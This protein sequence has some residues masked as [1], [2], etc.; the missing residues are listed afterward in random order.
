MEQE[1]GQLFKDIAIAV[2]CAISLSLF[3]SVLV[4]PMLAKQLYGV[5]EKRMEATAPLDGPRPPAML[6]VA[7][8]LLVPLTKLG[9]RM[10]D[11]IM[12]LLDRAISNP[13]SRIVT[14]ASLTLASILLVVA[15]FP[16]ME[17]LPQGNRNLVISILIPP[18]G[19]SYEERLEIGKY[20]YEAADPHFNTEKDGLPGIKD[21]FFV[22]APTINLFGAI[23]NS[24][25]RAGELTP[26]FTRILNSIP[27]MFGVSIQAS[28][29]EQGLGKGRVIDVDISGANLEQIV[30]AAGTLFGMAMQE[31]PGAQVRPVPALELL[32]PEVRFLPER[33]RRSEERRVGKEWHRLCRSRGSTAH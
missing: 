24:E 22:S 12:T 5:A 21:M 31:I 7:K 8:R 28:I 17:Y 23:S 25:Q 4:I 11:W 2:T 13:R 16:K 20:V 15:F 29:F 6:S 9:G 26:L 14:V 10:A 27:G 3:V 1:A 18:P 33:D 19:L 30:A 32:Y